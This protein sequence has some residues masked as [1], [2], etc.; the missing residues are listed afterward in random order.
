MHGCKVCGFDRGA[1]HM[2]RE[3]TSSSMFDWVKQRGVTW[4]VCATLHVPISIRAAE[5]GWSAEW[6][7]KQLGR[8]FNKLDRRVLKSAHRNHDARLSRWVTLE[9]CDG[10]GWHAHVALQTPSG[11]DQASFIT[12]V[13]KTWRQQYQRHTNKKFLER[14]CLVEPIL[15][16]FFYYSIKSVHDADDL[17]KGILDLENIHLPN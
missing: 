8:Y 15:G 4:D 11:M 12:L 1:L 16:E 2:K 9:T 6:L 17:S 13:E 3:T 10:V 7:S 14:L 5:R